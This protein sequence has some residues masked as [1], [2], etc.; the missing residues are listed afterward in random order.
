[1]A[2]SPVSYSAPLSFFCAERTCSSRTC[3]LFIASPP[4]ASAFAEEI[5]A[6]AARALIPSVPRRRARARVRSLRWGSITRTQC[7][8]RTEESALLDTPATAGAVLRFYRFPG[9]ASSACD[10]LLRRLAA[11]VK[12]VSPVAL[13]TE[14]CYYVELA[15]G[16]DPETLSAR[17][18]AGRTLRWLLA[19]TFE[20]SMV[21]Q[22]SSH[23]GA[24]AANIVAEGCCGRENK[25]LARCSEIAARDADP[26][27]IS[28]ITE[29][30]P[31]LSFTSAFST[32]AVSICRACG[33]GEQIVRVERAV[34]YRVEWESGA[35]VKAALAQ[36]Q[37]Q[38]EA[39][40][41]DRMTQM[42]Y[43]TP[44]DTFGAPAQPEPTQRVPVMEEGRAA[45]ERISDERGLAFDDWD[46]DFYTKLFR[47][48]MKRNPTDVE[49]F[50]MAQ[51]NSEHSRHWFFNAKA[52]AI[53]N[54]IIRSCNIHAHH[55]IIIGCC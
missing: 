42:V 35:M 7:P 25:L 16:V 10:T 5:R 32:N 19:E 29:I 24:G 23:F 1:M 13:D 22:N 20:P 55:F 34:R 21:L 9:L 45:L 30:G 40:V 44:L 14:F 51:S 48:E 27:I 31:R 2:P 53:N 8:N 39:A 54:F 4:S 3:S 50:D 41:H 46:L 49:C 38:L 47:D 36:S 33:L 6:R 17:T 18:R 11:T 26:A 28:T 12:P 15:P 43:A 52:V 37:R